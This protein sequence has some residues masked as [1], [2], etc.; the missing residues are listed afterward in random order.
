MLHLLYLT[1]LLFKL[2]LLL[3]DLPLALVTLISFPFLLALSR[4]FQRSS[5]IAYRRTRE[6][7]A[8]VIVHFVESMSGIRAVQ[9]F[10]REPRNARGQRL[11]HTIGRHHGQ[12]VLRGCGSHRAEPDVLRGRELLSHRLEEHRRRAEPAGDHEHRRAVRRGS[13]AAVHPA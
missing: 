12:A 5:A 3:L 4:W 13:G 6:A 2:A 9:A 10:R 7:I 1:A 8:L 11:V